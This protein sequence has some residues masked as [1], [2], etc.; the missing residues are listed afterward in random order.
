MLEEKFNV[1][2]PQYR[3]ASITDADE[4]DDKYPGTFQGVSILANA[5]TLLA[6]DDTQGS[7]SSC[8]MGRLVHPA[9]KR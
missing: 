1:S 9:M 8:V 4:K 5:R 2:S 6:S 7:S 3:I